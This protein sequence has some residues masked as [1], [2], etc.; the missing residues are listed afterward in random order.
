MRSRFINILSLALVVIVMLGA[1]AIPPAAAQTPETGDP[2][3]GG[4][5]FTGPPGMGN[6]DNY[7]A[8]P[9]APPPGCEDVP[10]PTIELVGVDIIVKFPGIW[11]M[12]VVN[13]VLEV[14]PILFDGP[15]P[16]IQLIQEP[17]PV[18]SPGE[19]T[20][21]VTGT[22]VEGLKKIASLKLSAA[23]VAA[24][25]A[26]LGVP[27]GADPSAI[28]ANPSAPAIQAIDLAGLATTG[29]NVDFPVAAGV[30]LLGAGGLLLLGA[31]KR[32]QKMVVIS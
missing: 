2:P 26:L 24:V 17:L 22:T 13:V 25:N 3:P 1:T 27:G 8:P 15:P 6:D 28:G 31:R 21:T 9:L 29:S 30:A 20:V 32:E 5:P 23:Q 4:R 18:L 19:H 11:L 14:N 12:C 7:P 16:A 10:L